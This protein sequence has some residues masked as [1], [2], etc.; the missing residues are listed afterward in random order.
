M[1]R[2]RGLALLILLLTGLALPA[3]ALA[4]ANLVRAEPAMGAQLDRPPPRVRAWFTETLE[5]EFS[6]LEVL[7]ASGARIDQGDSQVSADDPASMMV[8]LP[9]DLPEG[10]YTVS[11]KT[12]SALDGHAIRGLYTFSVGYAA[13][14]APPP[15]EPEVSPV[16]GL[17]AIVRGVQYLGQTLLMGGFLLAALVLGTVMLA[18]ARIFRPIW[19]ATTLALLVAA[20]LSLALQ[21]S[22]ASGQPLP[23]ALA[24]VGPLAFG[25]RYGTLWLIRVLLLLLL[26]G[27]AWK[28]PPRVWMWWSA[29]ALAGG[30]LLVNSLNSHSAAVAQL[31]A[32]AIGADWLHQATVSIWVGGLFGVA[33]LLRS[34]RARGSTGSPS[35]ASEIQPHA[36]LG[37]F[38]LLALASV[39]LLALSGVYL[40]LLHVGSWG[41]LLET[42][43]G[44]TV[45]AKIAL[46]A[47]MALLGGYHFLVVVPGRNPTAVRRFRG[48]VLVEAG[49]GALV[50]LLAGL[51]TSMLPAWQTY[52]QILATRPL[53]LTETANDLTLQLTIAPGR[54][55]LNSYTVRVTDS[56]GQPVS[57]AVRAVL[58]FS[59]LDQDLGEVEVPLESRGD[60]SYQAQGVELGVSGG[61]QA[62]LLVRRQGQDDARTA[63][64]FEVA[65]VAGAATQPTPLAGLPQ[66]DV[67][68]ALAALA[69]LGGLALGWYAWNNARGNRRDALPGLIAS[70]LVVGIGLYVGAQSLN[71]APT[72]GNADVRNPYPP[73]EQ[74]IATGKRIFDTHCAVCHG[75]TGRGD[76]PAA[77]ALRPPPADLRVHMAAGHTDGQLFD[78]VTNGFPGTAMPAWKDQLTE[79]ERWHVLNY[80]RTF[81]PQAAR[82]EPVAAGDE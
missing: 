35:V 21:A 45:L 68:T 58:R 59:F 77:A 17:E 7:D 30:L 43:Y 26:L 49:L 39:P 71:A 33:A 34:T 62:V 54:P 10:A 80:I 51:L 14:T 38:S 29:A 9:P 64:R 11:W 41:A 12:L 78:W 36:F 75:D 72:L 81:A 53:E 2:W 18:F 6:S 61:W 40:A 20:L 28:A 5:A 65:P 13:P 27:L 19:I 3:A 1:T 46:F 57:D 55:G 50:L 66:P 23:G 31:P 47:A 63:V 32:I 42:V 74:S 4:H 8:S 16:V 52:G 60:G 24:S 69:A 73:T 37:R 79:E 56:A 67:R 15:L 25:T 44:R 82:A 70:L 48:S 76:G 22:I